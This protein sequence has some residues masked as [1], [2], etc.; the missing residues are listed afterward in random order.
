V[1]NEYIYQDIDNFSLHTEELKES[2]TTTVETTFSKNTKVKGV[3]V[4]SD[5]TS[6]ISGISTGLTK[7]VDVSHDRYVLD[8]PL[9]LSYRYQSSDTRQEKVEE[10]GR[11]RVTEYMR[12]MVV[13]E[14]IYAKRLSRFVYADLNFRRVKSTS[15]VV[16]T[17][18]ERVQKTD[19]FSGRVYYRL[20]SWFL[21]G[22]YTRIVEDYSYT[23]GE[24]VETKLLLT[25]HRSFTRVF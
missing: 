24:N 19:S 8:G 16:I 6:P 18:N 21:G 12:S 17:G 2:N 14:G 22:E 4:Y 11:I 5:T 23:E 25:A 10:D 9:H 20:R 13:Y 1:S 7:R 15:E 3:M